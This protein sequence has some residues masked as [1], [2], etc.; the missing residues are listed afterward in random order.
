MNQKS[1]SKEELLS[2][3]EDLK[4]NWLATVDAMAD[5][6]QIVDSN[7]RIIKTNRALANFAE[8]KEIP[9][10]IGKKCYEVF[11][12]RDK[13]CEGCTIG[14]ENY[15][16]GTFKLEKIK[17]KYYFE[18]HSNALKDDDGRINGYVQMYRDQTE[19]QILHQQLLQS[20]KLS[21]IGL[22][23]G[24]I[25]HELNNPLGGILLFSQMLLRQMKEGDPFYQDVFEIEAAT[26][27]CRSIVQRLMDFSRSQPLDIKPSN[28]VVVDINEALNTALRFA[29]VHRNAKKI[30]IEENLAQDKMITFGERNNFIQLFLNLL[31]NA[32][33][34]M[35]DGGKIS[36]SS[37]TFEKKGKLWGQW[38]IK[39]TGI[40][41]PKEHLERIFDPFF[42]TKE[43]G[44]GTGL[45]LSIC[46]GIC[47]EAGGRISA[48]SEINKGSE[49][50]I[51]LPLSK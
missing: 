4:R 24:G 16:Q 34:A 23:A 19:Q 35:P 33:Q 50:L 21:S 46:Y 5:P 38:N 40:G 41:M 18:V 10:V 7:Y 44:K 31:Q 47:K 8:T 17:G 25:A 12:N 37:K 1:Q 2:F 30:D 45:G 6:F 22:L 27:R 32:M 42:T 29:K 13:P 14:K 11:A 51:E 28:E 48:K 49:F 43:P 9:A 20:E 26:Q 3:V 15:E 39:D 36:L